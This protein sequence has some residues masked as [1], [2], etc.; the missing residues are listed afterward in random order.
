[1]QNA[2]LAAAFNT[3]R[4]HTLDSLRLKNTSGQIIARLQHKAMWEAWNAWRAYH[5]HYVDVS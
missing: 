4:G 3:W 2:S 5:E 1:M